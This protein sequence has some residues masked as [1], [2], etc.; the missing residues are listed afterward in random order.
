[1]GGWLHNEVNVRHWDMNSD[2]VTYPRINRARRR[3]TA[4][5]ETNALPLHQT[6]TCVVWFVCGWQVK[7]CHPNCYTRATIWAI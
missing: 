3:L 6:T 5:I 2:T 1:M 4:L 7:L